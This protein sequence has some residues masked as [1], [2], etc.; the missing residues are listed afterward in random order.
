MLQTFGPRVRFE[1]DRDVD[2][3]RVCSPFNNWTLDDRALH[4]H[5]FRRAVGI[6]HPGLNLWTL[7]APHGALAIQ[8]SFPA[9]CSHP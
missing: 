7:L 3:A 1:A 9:D 2:F 6:D 5:Q 8:Q 4:Q